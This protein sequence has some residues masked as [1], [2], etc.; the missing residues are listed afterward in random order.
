MGLLTQEALEG[1]KEYTKR[2]IAKG[3]YKVGNAYYEA[4]VEVD[5]L[6]DGRI[7]ADV[8]VD[9]TVPG[10]ITVTEFQLFDTRDQLFCSKA[11]SISRR[12]SQ[13]GILYRFAFTITEG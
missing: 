13:E 12:D 4:P 7:V 1:Y 10:D 8:L 5:I 9:H 3:R 2:T 11:E 6:P